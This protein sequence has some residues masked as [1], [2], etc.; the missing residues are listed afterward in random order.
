MR[1]CGLGTQF[2]RLA[3]G[4]ARFRDPPHL[5]ENQPHPPIDIRAGLDASGEAEKSLNS[6]GFKV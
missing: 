2:H 3:Q 6:L 5:T 4:D 1:R